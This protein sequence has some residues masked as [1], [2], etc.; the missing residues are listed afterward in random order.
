[1]LAQ[2]DTK[3]ILTEAADDVDD[4]I[5][6]LLDKGVVFTN[7]ETVLEMLEAV[8]ELLTHDYGEIQDV[9]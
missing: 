5:Y 7:K 9:D 8:H 6:R 2:D 1:M 3:T 4:I